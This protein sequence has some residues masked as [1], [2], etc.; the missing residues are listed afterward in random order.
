MMVAFTDIS[1]Y[2]NQGMLEPLCMLIEEN[3]PIIAELGDGI[4]DL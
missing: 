4:S 1:S 3:A 2:V